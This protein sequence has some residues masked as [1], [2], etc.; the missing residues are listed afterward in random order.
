MQVNYN[1]CPVYPV[2]GEAVASELQNLPAETYPHT[3]EW[4]GRID[5]LR[6]ELELCE[7][8]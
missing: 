7:E 6:Q 4:I 2:A 3:W 8:K 5:K 1:F